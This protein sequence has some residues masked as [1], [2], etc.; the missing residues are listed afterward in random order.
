LFSF[1]GFN[2]G[3]AT[4]DGTCHPELIMA[5]TFQFHS[6]LQKLRCCSSQKLR[7]NEHPK[8]HHQAK[9]LIMLACGGN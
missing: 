6:H 5:A 7:E 9:D 1:L 4:L 8:F 2:H 3:A